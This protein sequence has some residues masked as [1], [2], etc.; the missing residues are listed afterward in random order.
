MQA[1][2]MGIGTR[3]GIGFALVL[4]LMV[5]AQVLAATRVGTISG[6]LTRINEVN[7]VK[8]RYAINFRGS[9]HD[10]AILMRDLVLFETR[11]DISRTVDEITTLARNYQ[12]S[13]VKLDELMSH[14]DLTDSREMKALADIK[15]VEART[16]P[17]LDKV[18]GHATGAKPQPD[19]GAVVVAAR[20]EFSEWLRVINVFIDMQ[21]E[22]NKAMGAE[23][24][25]VAGSFN[26]WMLAFGA[27]AV[28][29]GGAF[30]WWLVRSI[31]SP[32][33]DLKTVFVKVAQGDL[34][35]RSLV[36][37][38]DEFGHLAD[39]FN[40]LMNTMHD[41]IRGVSSATEQV[42]ASAMDIASNSSEM[43]NSV[44]IQTGEVRQASSALTQL[45]ASISDIA[46]KAG[47]TAQE[48]DEAGRVA[49]DGAEVVR[50]AVRDMQAIDQTVT[51]SAQIVGELGRKS[52]RIREIANVIADIADQTNL[53]AL[54]AAIEAARA[55]EHG[56]GFAVVADEVRKLAERTRQATEEVSESINSIRT[57]TERAVAQISTGTIRVKEGV[58]QANTAGDRM[59]DIE[60][61][62]G[63]VSSL[64]NDIAAS[65]KQQAEAT[66]QI[67]SSVNVIN[68]RAVELTHAATRS[69]RSAT[70]LQAKS[71]QLRGLVKRFKV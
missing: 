68:D 38:K 51:E 3:L 56:R 63:T 15:A 9:V 27:I 21:E 32:I 6:R 30:A 52:D 35:A 28:V 64:I 2:K 26:T 57:E 14:P 54:N 55:G 29:V 45:S 69:S 42:A 62:S 44:E 71:E 59:Q 41:A 18:I 25:G 8:Q 37:R 36:E 66:E 10:R 7:S 24:R 65:G 58:E 67:S 31:T 12:D 33:A 39:S 16:L 34:A 11:E 46:S 22:T 23:A 4:L 5:A 53:L 49:R 70:E 48:A 47:N 20:P 50:K 19:V 17:L 61:K 60:S 13:G 43:A 40:E 1:L